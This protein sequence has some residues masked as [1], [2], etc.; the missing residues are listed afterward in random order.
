VELILPDQP[1]D[2]TVRVGTDTTT[3]AVDLDLAT[4]SGTLTPVDFDPMTAGIQPEIQGS[5]AFWDFTWHI[6]ADG[7]YQLLATATS[8]QAVTTETRNVTVLT[9][10]SVL[11]REAS[12]SPGLTAIAGGYRVSFPTLPDRIYQLQ[13]SGDLE[14]W[15]DSGAPLN[16]AD[17]D[18]PGT[19]EVDDTS[20]ETPRFYRVLISAAP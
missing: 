7:Q 11:E 19:L 14:I 9:R 6:T 8:P 16:T 2:Y 3:T 15:I 4:G 12:E 20:G 1:L 10:E 13:V 17:A 18:G 5:S